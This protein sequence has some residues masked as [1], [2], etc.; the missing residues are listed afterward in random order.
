METD[1]FTRLSQ[2]KNPD[3]TMRK[4]GYRAKLEWRV[5]CFAANSMMF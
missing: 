2:G 4:L 5:S 1:A 3:A